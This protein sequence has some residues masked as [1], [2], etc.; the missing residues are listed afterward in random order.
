MR[1]VIVS[2]LLVA[3]ALNTMGCAGG[4]LVIGPVS[5]YTANQNERDRLQ[6]AAYTSNLTPE[7]KES[8]VRLSAVT[9]DPGAVGA[10]LNIDVG[11]LVRGDFTWGEV[12]KQFFGTLTD[13]GLYTGL[14]Y[15]AKKIVDKYS[16]SSSP[17]GSD[18]PGTGDDN[19]AILIDHNSGNIEINVRSKTQEGVTE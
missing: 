8:V 14:F 15:G 7:K 10:M 1:K 11:Q 19:T 17:Q 13:A 12:T 9:T 16:G 2:T 5:N 6:R 18:L 4:G 3:V